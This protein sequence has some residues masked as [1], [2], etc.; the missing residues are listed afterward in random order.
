MKNWRTFD[1]DNAII[2]QSRTTAVTTDCVVQPLLYA[3]LH[4]SK[5]VGRKNLTVL[6]QWRSQCKEKE[7]GQQAL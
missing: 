6:I 1:N 4:I 3:K 7:H 5:Y 2:V